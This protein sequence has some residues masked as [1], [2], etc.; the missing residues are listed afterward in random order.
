MIG[1]TVS[2]TRVSNAAGPPLI[3]GDTVYIA[4]SSDTDNTVAARREVELGFQEGDSVEIRS[5]LDEGDQVMS[6][7]RDAVGAAQDMRRMLTDLE[8]ALEGPPRGGYTPHL[9]VAS[10]SLR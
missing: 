5:G 8:N 4:S 10:L 1:R 3:Y 6:C 7:H 9:V 2:S